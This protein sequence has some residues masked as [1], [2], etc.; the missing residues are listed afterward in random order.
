MKTLSNMLLMLTLSAPLFANNITPPPPP[1]PEKLAKNSST[2]DFPAINQTFNSTVT[3]ANTTPLIA[4]TDANT[5]TP[6]STG[7]R[8]FHQQPVAA[9]RADNRRGHADP[10]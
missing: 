10:A 1:P 2:Q 3:T 4:A 9:N 6:K 7:R 5:P 8:Q